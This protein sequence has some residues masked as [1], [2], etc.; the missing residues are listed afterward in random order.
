MNFDIYTE[1]VWTLCQAIAENDYTKSE[2]KLG[3]VRFI[4]KT[5]ICFETT[6]NK[7]E[8]LSH[9]LMENIKDELINRYKPSTVA[10]TGDVR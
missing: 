4:Y 9:N 5:I 3:K 7:F 2:R 8:R 6:T 1:T 10:A